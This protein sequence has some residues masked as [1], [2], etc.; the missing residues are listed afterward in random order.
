MNVLDM[1]RFKYCPQCGKYG[2]QQG[3]TASVAC[4]SCGYV[5]YHS[6][7]AAVVGIVE[8]GN[9]IVITRRANEPHKGM[10]AL[11][12]G[13]IEYQ[14]DLES[15]LV[16]ELREELGVAAT[17]SKYL[18]S[19]GSRYL[20]RD[21]LYFTTVAYFIVKVSDMSGAKANDD[22]DQFLLL[23]PKELNESELAF[24]ADRSALEKYC[25]LGLLG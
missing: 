7:V 13:F 9:Q 6:P 24:E 4:S 3:T 19:F 16:R 23:R 21:V 10:L 18:A 14:E 1:T 2:I 11:P 8:C 12:G 20:F 5:Y 25:D 22:I 15:A 17:I